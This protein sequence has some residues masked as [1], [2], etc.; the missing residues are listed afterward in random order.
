MSVTVC[1]AGRGQ[2]NGQV[3]DVFVVKIHG[4]PAY[5]LSILAKG[6]VVGT[7]HIDQKISDKIVGHKLRAVGASAGLCFDFLG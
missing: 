2:G 5:T 3:T 6:W 1:P 4:H 7:C